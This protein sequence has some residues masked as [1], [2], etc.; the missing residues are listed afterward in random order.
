MGLWGGIN[1]NVQ[2]MGLGVTSSRR[3]RLISHFKSQGNPETHYEK[4]CQMMMFTVAV[5][6]MVM[7]L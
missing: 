5:M 1:M 7:T 2:C 4:Q 3:A 6:M